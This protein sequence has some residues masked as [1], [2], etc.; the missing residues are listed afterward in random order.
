[1]QAFL[2][3]FVLTKKR[4]LSHTAASSSSFVSYDPRRK[5]WLTKTKITKRKA[6]ALFRRKNIDTV[7]GYSQT[8]CCQ[9]SPDFI[10]A[11]KNTTVMQ[12]E[13]TDQV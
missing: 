9:A 3:L 4:I 8:A 13:A 12:D 5:L 11:A 10:V 6:G 7:T 1:M 2:F